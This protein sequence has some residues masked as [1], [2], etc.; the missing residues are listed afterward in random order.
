V[1]V[2]PIKRDLC[3][4][5]TYVV[6]V[7]SAHIFC[8]IH[9]S[10]SHSRYR[11]GCRWLTLESE[12]W[13]FPLR[14]RA[15]S[16]PLLWAYMKRRQHPHVI[17]SAL[18]IKSP[19]QKMWIITCECTFHHV[20][21]CCSV[22]QGVLQFVVVCCSVFRSVGSIIPSCTLSCFPLPSLSPPPPPRTPPH[23]TL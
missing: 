22:L 2:L 3:L 15:P 13:P 9:T 12:V 4:F 8:D 10:M 11:R 20:V 1:S 16:H 14:Y 19:R 5:P 21:A 7:F 18:T 23:L 6:S 17:G